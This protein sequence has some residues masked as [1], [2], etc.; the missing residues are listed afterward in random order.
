LFAIR[1]AYQGEVG[2]LLAGQSAVG[3]SRLVNRDVSNVSC[4]Q[5]PDPDP[6]PGMLQ[7]ARMAASYS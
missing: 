1:T 5:A 6:D 3:N 7:V 4:K 2:Y